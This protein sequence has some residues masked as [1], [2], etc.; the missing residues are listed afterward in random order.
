MDYIPDRALIA[1]LI[2]VVKKQAAIDYEFT[3]QNT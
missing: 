1:L 2:L 3:T